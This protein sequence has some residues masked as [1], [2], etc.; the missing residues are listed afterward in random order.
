[1]D[2]IDASALGDVS[3]VVDGMDASALGDASAVADGMDANGLSDM[4]AVDDRMDASALGDTDAVAVSGCGPGT[5]RLTPVH[6]GGDVEL[7]SAHP[8]GQ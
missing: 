4:R 3:A 7:S 5:P 1:M 8:Y 6:T 2:A